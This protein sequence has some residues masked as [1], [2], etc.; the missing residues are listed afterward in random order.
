MAERRAHCKLR[1]M[2]GRQTYLQQ[3]VHVVPDVEV[4]QGWVERLEI[5]VVDILEYQA[6]GL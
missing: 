5:D 4:P 3:L 2:P 1:E 6:G